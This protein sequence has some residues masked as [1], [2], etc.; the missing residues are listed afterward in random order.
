[1]DYNMKKLK[2]YSA[3]YCPFAQRVWIALKLA[4]IDFEYTETNV[5]CKTLPNTREFR[6]RS[7]HKT[8]PTLWNGIVGI[9]DST[10][11]LY[12]INGITKAETITSATNDLL[13]NII[14]NFVSTFYGF[15]NGSK[16]KED[17]ES[18]SEILQQNIQSKEDVSSVAIFP[19]LERVM[20]GVLEWYRNYPVEEFRSKFPSLAKLYDDMMAIREV[21]ETV[22]DIRSEASMRTQPFAEDLKTR[23]DYMKHVYA[24]YAAGNVKA[25]NETLSS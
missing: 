16:S 9:D 10:R 19:F 8:L 6:S 24:K 3:D 12:H 15:L 17:F 5:F 22:W 21:R 4:N 13:Q 1:M 11:L 25:V 18:V 7:E 2:L 23:K 14:P 20:L